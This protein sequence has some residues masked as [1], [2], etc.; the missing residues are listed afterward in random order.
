[1]HIRCIIDLHFSKRSNFFVASGL[2][3]CLVLMSVVRFALSGIQIR[4]KDRT[5]AASILADVL[6]N[7]SKNYT[8]MGD[9][10]LLVLGIPRGGVGIADII[11]RKLG[12]EFGILVVS[13]LGQSYDREKAIGAVTEYETSYL[14]WRI[15]GEMH[16]SHE[17]VEEEMSTHKQEIQ[18]RISLYRKAGTSGSHINGK[19]VILADD[20]ATTGATIIAAARAVMKQ[21]PSNLIIALPVAP[22][23]LVH[24]LKENAGNVEVILTPTSDLY[25][26]SKY[27][28]SF[29]PVTHEDVLRIIYNREN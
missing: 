16:I 22:K 2:A 4:F 23:S 10:N 26:I 17:Y 25:T 14:D 8:S 20:G 29:V 15:I 28:E 18:H 21:N 24:L 9:Q 3:A 27:Y 12:A 5:A 13:K 11:A 1:M 6:K 19:T 7:R